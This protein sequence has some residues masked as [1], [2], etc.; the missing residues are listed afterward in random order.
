MFHNILLCFDQN[1][2]NL[3]GHT[4]IFFLQNIFNILS[5]T[6]GNIGLYAPGIQSLNAGL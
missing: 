2:P 6:Y 4:I 5:N 3:F 1:F